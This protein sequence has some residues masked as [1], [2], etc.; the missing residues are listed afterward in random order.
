MDPPSKEQMSPCS[1]QQKSVSSDIRS[2]VMYKRNGE[3][4]E[5]ILT[6][7]TQQRAVNMKLLWE[8]LSNPNSATTFTPTDFLFSN[9]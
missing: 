9:A 5:F 8:N 1:V 4:N 6:V 3:V 7:A 2:F